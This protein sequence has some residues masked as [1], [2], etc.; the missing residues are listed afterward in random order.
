MFSLFFFVV[1]SLLFSLFCF[2]SFVFSLCFLSLSL[3]LYLFSLFVFSLCFL[4][5]STSLSLSLSSLS[6]ATHS[7]PSLPFWR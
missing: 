3:S 7:I 6:L 4:S 2:L 1:F 5:C